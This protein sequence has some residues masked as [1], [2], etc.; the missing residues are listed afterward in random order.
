MNLE[1][2]LEVNSS[3]GGIAMNLE[4]LACLYDDELQELQDCIY[5]EQVSRELK[6]FADKNPEG[7]PVKLNPKIGKHVE[8][9]KMVHQTLQISLRLAKYFVDNKAEIN[10]PPEV[11]SELAALLEG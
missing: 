11:V 6:K 8:L 3:F 10:F 7:I 9:I 1:Y 4:Y 5:K 2:L